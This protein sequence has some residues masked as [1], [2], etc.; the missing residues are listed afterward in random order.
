[1]RSIFG[2]IWFWLAMLLI[3][4]GIIFK[5]SDIDKDAGSKYFKAKMRLRNVHFSQMDKEFEELR[6]FADELEMDDGQNVMIASKVRALFF[7]KNCATK[8]AELIAS[9]ADKNPFEIKFY[10]DVRV[11]TSEN[12][13]LRTDELRYFASRKELFTTCTVTIWKD[14]IIITG[15]E[16]KYNTQTKLGSLAKD[17]LIRIW[18]K[19]ASPSTKIASGTKRKPLQS[20]S[21]IASIDDEI[22][23]LKEPVLEIPEEGKE[24]LWNETDNEK[25]PKKTEK[26]GSNDTKTASDTEKF[27]QK[28]FNPLSKEVKSRPDSK[29]FSPKDETLASNN[30]LSAQK[31]NELITENANP[32]PKKTKIKP[33]IK[34]LP[35]KNATI[36]STSTQ[37]MPESDQRRTEN[38]KVGKK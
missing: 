18:N 1:M 3:F 12:E 15:R 19:Q 17:V 9:H 4:L 37:L 22:T 26:L 8:S 34:I 35:T 6:V 30:T 36:A 29:K 5:E 33:N 24:A 11:K 16:L 20:Q 7:D 21:Q 25:L 10:G 13:R 27:P 38:E 2:S 28:D 32:T 23:S 14:D 31:S